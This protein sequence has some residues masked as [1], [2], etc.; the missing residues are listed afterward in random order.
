ML[1]SNE[2]LLGQDPPHSNY[3]E[4]YRRLRTALFAL[5]DDR[6]YR[7]LLITSAAPNEGKTVTSLNISVL[8]AQ[9]GFRVILVDGDFAHPGIHYEWELAEAPGIT[10]ACV[11]PLDINKIIQSTELE[12]LK[13]VTAGAASLR[14]S[15]LASSAQMP[16]IMNS[17]MDHCDLLVIDSAPVLGSAGTL[18]LARM[19]DCVVMVARARG[20]VAP[21]RRAM[22]LLKD[23]GRDPRGIIVNDILAQDTP[24]HTYYYYGSTAKTP[25]S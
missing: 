23:I 12:T 18:Q 22:K 21:V 9:A 24:A 10:D 7:S 13:V 5:R 15:D 20:N 17:L 8:I 19:V 6:P 11:S 4:A 25:L 14:G 2:V 3:L 1:R 16:A